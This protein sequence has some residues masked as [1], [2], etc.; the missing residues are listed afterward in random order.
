[1]MGFLFKHMTIRLW[2]TMLIG[3]LIV[4]AVLPPAAGVLGPAWMIVPAVGLFAVVFWLTGIGL[5]ALGR[6]RLNNLLKEAAV[7]D[8]AGMRRE[9]RQAFIRAADTV[10]SFLFSPLSRR[11]PAGRLLAQMT[12]FQLA[13]TEAEAPSDTLMEAYLR[14]FPND[15]D[16]AV[17]WLEGVL[18]GREAT[19]QAQ[20]IAARIGSAHSE[21]MAVQRMLA[22]FYLDERRCDFAALQ[23]YR[24]LV[25]AGQPLAGDLQSD[26]TALFLSQPR[27]DKLA[28]MVYLAQLAR[29]TDGARL[30]PAI[31]AC[32]SRIHPSPD[33]LWLL[34]KADAALAGIDPGQRNRMA[35]EFMPRTAGREAIRPSAAKRIDW[36]A[37]SA[38]IRNA[39]RGSQK[40]ASGAVPRMRRLRLVFSTG[41]ARSTLRWAALG[42]FAVGVGWLLVSTALHLAATFKPA[43]SEPQAVAMPVTDPF[44]LQV[45]AYLKESDA[46]RYVDQLKKEGQAAYWTRASGAGKTWFQ[47]RISHFETKDEARTV[48]E[49]LKK[50]GLIGDYYVANYKR[51]DVP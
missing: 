50:R 35:A 47:V 10:D 41:L 28:L 49:T 7:W 21:D 38:G 19:P 6:R 33:N 3:S 25:E 29:G 26:L 4:L 23:T 9:A 13:L 46:Q 14:R 31:A 45:A 20:D 51:P 22:R 11:D 18:A 30:I 43:E 15:R 36:P 8:R 24:L 42:L 5:A 16:A 40:L 17:K 39:L 2:A 12:R 1:M 32:C 37:I 44:T 34:E 48:G 27:A